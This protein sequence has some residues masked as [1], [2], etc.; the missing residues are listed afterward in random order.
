MIATAGS[1]YILFCANW[2]LP[3]T[4][5]QAWARGKSTVLR[6]LGL[7]FLFAPLILISTVFYIYSARQWNTTLW[8]FPVLFILLFF[9]T[10]YYLGICAIVIDRAKVIPAA[11]TSLKFGARHLVSILILIGVYSY[12][13]LILFGG[14][15]SFPMIRQRAMLEYSFDLNLLS[16]QKLLSIPGTIWATKLFNL[17]IWPWWLAVLTKAYLIFK[18]KATPRA[19]T[20][21]VTVHIRIDDEVINKEA[22]WEVIDPVWWTANIYAGEAE[23]NQSLAPF[24]NEQRLLSAV[25]WYIME[26]N[27]GGHD[28]FYYNSTGIV[29]KDAL[30]GLQSI[31]LEEI[32]TLLEESAKRMGGNPSLDR[33]KRWEQMETHNPKFD[34]LDDKLYKLEDTLD[35][36]AHMQTFIEQHRSAFYFDGD[37]EKPESA[38]TF[39]AS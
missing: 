38:I 18:A 39:Q 24:S 29:W 26:V 32:A 22:P 6:V 31:G 4:L 16:L 28:Q 19:K 34:D 20:N 7:S 13:N 23:Y 12:L 37:V 9:I 15:L 11:W 17:L 30:A 2:G 33:E 8:P 14:L 27:N 5:S 35:I 25:N 36:D 3:T 10:I 1:F 21:K